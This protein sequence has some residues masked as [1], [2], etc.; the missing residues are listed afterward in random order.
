MVQ[1]TTPPSPADNESI[2]LPTEILDKLLAP[3]PKTILIGKIA[4]WQKTGDEKRPFE[5][6]QSKT[7]YVLTHLGKKLTVK[8]LREIRALH[9]H[10]SIKEYSWR[11]FRWD[12]DITEYYPELIK[13]QFEKVI[14]KLDSLVNI[15]F[16]I[17]DDKTKT[18]FLLLEN[19]KNEIIAESYIKRVEAKIPRYFRAY[20][21]LSK[22]MLLIQER[23]KQ[24]TK[25]F[26]TLFKQALNVK[27]QELKINAMIIREFVKQNPKKLT[28]LIVKIPQEVAGFAGL[29]ELTIAGSDVIKGSKGLMDRHETSPILIGPWVGVANSKL[30]LKV[31]EALKT[32]GINHILKL[33]DLITELY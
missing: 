25:D 13:D 2:T 19:W 30:E 6:K 32:T 9:E 5:K 17:V 4:Q 12:K 18:M 20:F 8:F 23:S 22:K 3:I 29:S 27:V 21:S 11:L 28:K 26:L 7:E 31:G 14:R 16:L 10:Y 1:M 24:A 15:D 33:F